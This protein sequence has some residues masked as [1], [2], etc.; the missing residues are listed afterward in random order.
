MQEQQ[1]QEEEQNDVGTTLMG[2]GGKRLSATVAATAINCTA[3]LSWSPKTNWEGG[4]RRAGVM[5][6]SDPELIIFING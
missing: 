3:S 6:G 2:S 1:Q 4:I 5:K